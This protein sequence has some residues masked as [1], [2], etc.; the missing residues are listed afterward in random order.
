MQM[1]ESARY[2]TANLEAFQTLAWGLEHRRVILEQGAWG[3]VLPQPPGN[4]ILARNLNNMFVTLYS[5]NANVR[6]TV[7]EYTADV[8]KELLRK[9]LEF[10]DKS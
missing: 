4:Y 5:S 1:G 8:N 3:E 9:R 10:A 2:S 7:Q 6:K